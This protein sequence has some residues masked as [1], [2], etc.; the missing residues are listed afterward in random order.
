MKS[1]LLIAV[2]AGGFA[3]S[4]AA[5]DVEGRILDASGDP[6]P[7]A[8]VL[9]TWHA[10]TGAVDT[11]ETCLHAERFTT[12]TDGRYKVPG[13]SPSLVS[14]GSKPWTE[15]RMF[16]SDRVPLWLAKPVPNG[17]TLRLAMDTDEPEVRFHRL[18]QFISN[19]TGQRCGY[20]DGSNGNL[21]Q[22]HMALFDEAQ[23]I[24]PPAL[25]WQ[26]KTVTRGI[27]LDLVDFRKETTGTVAKDP[28]DARVVNV[29]PS[30][31]FDKRALLK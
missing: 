10:N 20:K 26:L 18:L 24:A 9:V 1:I 5:A 3:A 27:D 14:W 19:M 2:L 29:N 7:G 25:A 6:V 16:K 11:S 21:Y 22:M 31:G 15:I 28:N 4:C 13:W 12:G 17:L 23:R 30:D 8:L